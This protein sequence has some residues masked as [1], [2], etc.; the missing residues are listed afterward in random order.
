MAIFATCPKGHKL[1]ARV[2]HAGKTLPCPAC[3]ETVVMPTLAGSDSDSL[4]EATF[5]D[6]FTEPPHTRQQ[7]PP[8]P[9]SPFDAETTIGASSRQVRRRAQLVIGGIAG[10]LGLA[11]LLVLVVAS[12]V[13][14]RE[15]LVIAFSTKLQQGIILVGILGVSAAIY[16]VMAF[17]GRKCPNCKKNWA[18]QVTGDCRPSGCLLTSMERRYICRH[19][20][21]SVWKTVPEGGGAG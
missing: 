1:K 10:G 2:E 14:G 20:E 17:F 15:N 18:L 12:F 3:G 19:C 16:Y 8:I 21:T 11:I 6:L 4:S 5:G 9:H 7:V 13:L